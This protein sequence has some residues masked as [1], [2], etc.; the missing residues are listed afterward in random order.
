MLKPDLVK[1]AH[2]L[3]FIAFLG[4]WGGG[5]EGGRQPWVCLNEPLAASKVPE[6]AG[7]GCQGRVVLLPLLQRTFTPLPR[8]PPQSARLFTNR[9]ERIRDWRPGKKRQAEFC[10]T[11]P[12]I[13]Q[14]SEDMLIQPRKV[15]LFS[16]RQHVRN[17]AVQFSVAELEN[18][19]LWRHVNF[20]S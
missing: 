13:P 12:L 11:P 14:T 5:Q 18:H 3:P 17:C 8:E 20:V 10:V 1:E 2:G 4:G 9:A 7:A 15:L 6:H 19:S 16:Q